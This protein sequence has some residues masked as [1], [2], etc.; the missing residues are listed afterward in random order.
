MFESD[1]LAPTELLR[2]EIGVPLVSSRLNLAK[3]RW[4]ARVIVMNPVRIPV[5]L[6]EISFWGVVHSG[7]LLAGASWKNGFQVIKDQLSQVGVSNTFS[8]CLV[9]VCLIKHVCSAK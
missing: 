9:Q 1:Q 3:L 8:L 7:C 4:D 5:S 2:W 6:P